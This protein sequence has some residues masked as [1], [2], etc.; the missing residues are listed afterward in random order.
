M[1]RPGPRPSRKE[2]SVTTMTGMLWELLVTGLLLYGL[3]FVGVAAVTGRGGVRR[4]QSPDL[5]DAPIFVTRRNGRATPAT[6][7]TRTAISDD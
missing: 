6:M 7:S 3:A 1:P 2:E 4:L 5:Y